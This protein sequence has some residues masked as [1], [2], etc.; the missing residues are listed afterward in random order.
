[1]QPNALQAAAPPLPADRDA[2][3]LRLAPAFVWL[4]TGLAVLSPAYRAV[5]EGYLARLGLPA[6]PM[7]AAC[8]GEV[9]L[10]L[11]V[12]LLPPSRWLTAVQVG[13]VAT[14]TA[15]LAASEPLLLAHPFGVLT[16]NVPIV[17]CVLAAQEAAARGFTPRATW[18]LRGGMAAIW[19]TEGLFPKLLFQQPLEL[20][21]VANSGL[22]PMSPSLF[23]SLMGAAQVLSGILALVLRGAPLRILL[24]CQLLALVALPLLVSWQ[25]PTLWVHPFGPLTKNVPILAGTWVVLRRCS[26]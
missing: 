13:A 9:V 7:W 1:M 22:V 20:A 2:L 18:L 15:I 24:G 5:G 10:G 4:F 12:A 3:L 26:S 11:R 25:D 17:A 6:W 14:F 23:L 16:N 21:V 8:A 19:I